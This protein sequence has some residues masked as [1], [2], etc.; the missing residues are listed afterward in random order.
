ME[1]DVVKALKPKL[2]KSCVDNIYSKWVKSQPI[3]F[4]RN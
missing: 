3:N 2:Y 1:L 4:S